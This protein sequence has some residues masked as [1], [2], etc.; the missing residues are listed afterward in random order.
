MRTWVLAVFSVAT[1]ALKA[2]DA[3]PPAAGEA[4]TLRS[5]RQELVSLKANVE[6]PKADLPRIEIPSFPSAPDP[7]G[8]RKRPPTEASE[9]KKSQGWLIDLMKKPDAGGRKSDLARDSQPDEELT[10]VAKPADKPAEGVA[11]APPAPEPVQ[12]LDRHLAAEA[13]NPLTAFMSQWISPEDRKLLIEPVEKPVSGPTVSETTEL[14]GLQADLGL[15]SAVKERPAEAISEAPASNPYLD[16]LN[17][18]EKAPESSAIPMP[19]PL[20]A[21][22]AVSAGSTGSERDARY[23]VPDFAKPSDDDKYFKQLNRF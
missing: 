16:L 1:A 9:A 19:A 12:V 23:A 21:A 5:A 6:S 2:A 18:S 3:P 8:P 10:T 17:G 7:A 13:G 4:D 20:I 11:L 22:P 14:L 15:E